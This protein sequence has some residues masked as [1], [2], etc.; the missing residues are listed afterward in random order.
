MIIFPSEAI[1]AAKE[2]LILWY[3]AALPSLFPFAVGTTLLINSGFLEFMSKTASLT[4]KKILKVSP[5]GFFVFI[6]GL[7]SGYP[8]GIKT[9]AEMY[10]S[11]LLTRDEALRLSAFCNNSGPLFIIGSLSAVMLKSVSAGLPVLICHYASALITGIVLGYS[12]KEP[13]KPEKRPSGSKMPFGLALSAAVERGCSS[14]ITVGG[15]IVLFAV[16]TCLIYVSGILTFLFLPLS[17]LGGEKILLAKSFLLGL[18][19]MTNGCSLLCSCDT[20]L[21]LPLLCFIVSFGGLSVHAQSAG[22]LENAGLPFGPYI[23]GK[24]FSAFLS[25]FMCLFWEI[26]FFRG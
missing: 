26:L 23:K 6:S 15:Y 9:L 22:F 24:I 19:E 8:I 5:E 21:K 17:F 12:A 11:G 7:L 14:M 25:F 1:A 18:L 13:P 20:R 16:V 2:G 4:G 10:E 3:R